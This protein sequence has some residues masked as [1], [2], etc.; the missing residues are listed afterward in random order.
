MQADEYSAR[1]SQRN[2]SVNAERARYGPFLDAFDRKIKL[3]IVVELENPLSLAKCSRAWH[4]QVHSPRTKAMWLIRRYGIHTLF[5][6]IRRRENIDVINSLFEQQVHLSHYLAQRLM[7]SYGRPDANLFNLR[8]S[9]NANQGI[10]NNNTNSIPWG[11]V[12]Y[13]IFLRIL[14]EAHK[15][16]GKDQTFLNGDDM[17]FFRLL[18]MTGDNCQKLE[19]LIREYGF[20]PFP[21]RPHGIDGSH[22]FDNNTD[23]YEDPDHLNDIA[24]AILLNPDLVTCWQDNGYHEVV[25]DLNDFVM[26]ALL[27]SLDPPPGWVPLTLEQ[28]INTLHRLS[29][30]GFKL[31]DELVADVT[32]SEPRVRQA[33]IRAF[34]IIRGDAGIT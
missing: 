28:V 34:A 13:N 8:R 30:I 31:T 27:P 25:E 23:G 24:H 19:N 7:K 29:S 22:A 5:H 20:V 16:F 12:A 32:A 1:I 26:R 15:K 9:Y 33:F 18:S 14:G 3:Q 6:T 17:E 2:S 4:N 10:D 21:P 11:D